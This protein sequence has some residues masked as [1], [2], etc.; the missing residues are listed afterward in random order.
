MDDEITNATIEALANPKLYSVTD[1]EKFIRLSYTRLDGG[2][3]GD[4]QDRIL[5]QQIK[6]AQKEL[7]KRGISIP[8]LTQFGLIRPDDPVAG[9]RKRTKRYRRRVKGGRRSTVDRKSKKSRRH[10]HRR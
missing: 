9:G 5:K 1:L 2:Q 4:L 6:L 8:I 10:R 7:V 3:E